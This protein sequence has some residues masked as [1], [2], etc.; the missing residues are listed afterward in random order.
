MSSTLAL[1]LDTATA[2]A[3]P[4]AADPAAGGGDSPWRWGWDALVGIGTL[5]LAVFTASLAAR[6]R[7]LAN[8]AGEDSR[9]QWRPV[10]LPIVSGPGTGQAVSYSQDARR[11]TVRIRNAGRGPALY[12]RTALELAGQDGAVSP[13]GGPLGALAPGDER[14][15]TFTLPVD[16][17][18][19]AQL[20]L[21]Y[22]DLADRQHATSVTITVAT[23]QDGGRDL[24]AYDVHSWADHSATAHGDAVY[25][26]PGLRDAGPQKRPGRRR[27]K[28]A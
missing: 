7:S 13:E 23:D 3:T 16:V 19:A 21:D 24:R 22:R 5:G 11:M 2:T 12:V 18:S 10:L 4:H 17:P 28:A 6:T 15:L 20:L 1:L 27:G 25:P 26:Q 14:P 9:A 8:A